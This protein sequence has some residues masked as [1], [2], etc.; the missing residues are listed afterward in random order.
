MRGIVLIGLLLA[1]G[2]KALYPV[3]IE[4]R[5]RQAESNNDQPVRVRGIGTPSEPFVELTAQPPQKDQRSPSSARHSPSRSSVSP[6]PRSSGI[7]TSPSAATKNKRVVSHASPYVPPAS[8]AKPVEELLDL[9]EKK[10]N[11]GK[12][13]ESELILERALRIDPRNPLI[14]YHLARLKL[15]IGAV[16]MATEFAREGLRYASPENEVYDILQQIASP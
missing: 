10:K 11:E 8:R 4:D 15:S 9:A 2:C 16:K 13:G 12:P 7:K 5:S 14:Y 1:F 3:P 6:S